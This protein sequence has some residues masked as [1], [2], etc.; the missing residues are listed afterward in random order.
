MEVLLVI[1]GLALIAFLVFLL[2]NNTKQKEYRSSTL[3]KEE[4][5]QKYEDEMKTIIEKYKD[6]PDTLTIKKIEYLKKASNKI[7]NNIFFSDSEAK[8]LVQRLASL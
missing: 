6:D 4:L 3:K 5:I 7:H 2:G 8:A 1:I